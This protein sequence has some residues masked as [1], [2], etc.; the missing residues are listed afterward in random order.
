MVLGL[1]EPPLGDQLVLDPPN[2]PDFLHPDFLKA[3]TMGIPG[4]PSGINMFPALQTGKWGWGGLEGG[5]GYT[6]HDPIT[7]QLPL[8]MGSSRLPSSREGG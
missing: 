5:G 3:C 4:S 7:T 6:V 8:R 1:P 2:E